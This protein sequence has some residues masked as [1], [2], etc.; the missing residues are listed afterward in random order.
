[1]RRFSPGL[2]LRLV[3]TLMLAALPL[4]AQQSPINARITPPPPPPEKP[5]TPPPTAKPATQSNGGAIAQPGTDSAT[6]AP[7]IAAPSAAP[8]APAELA[9]P[10]DLPGH[11]A[12]PAGSRIAVV[13]DTPLSTR[14]SRAGQK[15]TFRTSNA[16]RLEDGLEIPPDTA[17]TGSVVEVKRPGGFGKSGVLRVKVDGFELT[18]GASAPVVAHL[19]S[20]DI[21]AKGRLTTDNKHTTD[22]YSL[23]MYTLEGTLVG[24]QI[25]GGKGAAVG[26][27]AGALA[28]LIIMMSHRGQDVYLEPG[29]PFQV[30][31]EKPVDL[32]G[33]SVWGAQH[34]Y[35]RA[36]PV[37]VRSTDGSENGGFTRESDTSGAEASPGGSDPDP[38]RPKLKHRPR[39][40]QP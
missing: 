6:G 23:A 7:P 14:I 33:K 19:E 38:D 8:A 25:K 36:H 18:A 22:L 13:L 35:A 17:F 40:P 11:V 27:G 31:L 16:V 29:M 34:D 15:V 39:S 10:P 4:A 28:A 2:A 21:N 9:P 12:I 32:P 5:A 37:G 24:S 3:L 20:Q 1:M 30:L 26:A